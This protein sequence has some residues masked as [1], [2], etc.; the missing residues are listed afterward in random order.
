MRV[1]GGAPLGID[2]I[3]GRMYGVVRRAVRTVRPVAR[4]DATLARILSTPPIATEP[5]EDGRQADSAIGVHVLGQDAHLLPA[6]WALK[7]FYHF[8]DARCPLTVHLQGASTGQLRAGLHQHFPQAR[9]VT[10]EAADVVVEP[11]L[12]TRRME[13]L[14]LMRRRLFLMM[15]LIDIRVLACTPLALYFDTDVLFFR[16]AA[17]LMSRPAN[18][19]TAPHLFM[20][21]D[22][23][24]Y[25]ITPQQAHADLGVPLVPRVNTGLMRLRVEAVDLSACERFLTHRT[26]AQP[27][28]HLEQS[29]H[30]LN[31]SANGG[32]ELLPQGYAMLKDNQAVPNMIARHYVSP[33]RHQFADE[34][35]S[36]LIES[37]FLDVRLSQNRRAS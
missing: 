5:I 13:R 37:G 22:H 3:L 4:A 9:F 32:V 23:P 18:L 26:M 17:Q 12:Q 33:I 24:S 1:T 6:L 25:C 7:T 28:W 20:R 14:L 15:K 36:H 30:A 8:A 31:A 21:D 19:H 29:L 35:V 11:W 16:R 34:G 27:H 10:Q 2:T